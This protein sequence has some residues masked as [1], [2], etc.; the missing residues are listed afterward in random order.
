MVLSRSAPASDALEQRLL[1][2]LLQAADL[3]ADSR[4]G[5]GQVQLL[6]RFVETAQAGSR[7]ESAQGAQGRPMFQHDK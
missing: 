5:Q 3:L 4:L 7:F 2:V 1:E 6:R